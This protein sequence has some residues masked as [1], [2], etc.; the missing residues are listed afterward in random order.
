[1]RRRAA[2]RRDRAIEKGVPRDRGSAKK[3]EGGDR[4]DRSGELMT[5]RA[6]R[7]RTASV[8]RL[9]DAIAAEGP[10]VAKILSGSRN[11]NPLEDPAALRAAFEALRAQHEELMVADEELREQLDETGRLGVA[12]EAERE[13][14]ADLFAL[15]PDAIVVTDTFGMIHEAND[16]AAQLFRI[17]RRF[18]RAKPLA[19]LVP[20]TAGDVI[21][22]LLRD[23]RGCAD[24]IALRVRQR[25]GGEV[26]VEARLRAT[27]RGKSIVWILREVEASAAPVSD[28][29]R[30]LRDRTELLERERRLR[31]ELERTNRAKD[32]FIAVLAHDL[33]APLN[34]ILGWTQLLQQEQLDRDGRARALATIARN[35]TA[36]NQLVEE[37][38]DIARIDEHQLQLTLSALDFGPLVERGVARLLSD[39]NESG[40]DLTGSCEPGLTV[41][42][43]RSRLDQILANLLANALEHTPSGGKVLVEATREGHRVR[44]RVSDTGKGI[45]SNLLPNVFQLYTQDRTDSVSRTG[46][47]LGLHIV[48]QLVELHDGTVEAASDGEGQG[49]RV[50][51]YLPLH[52]ER[53]APSERALPVERRSLSRL[54]VLVVDDERDERELIGAILARAGATVLCA[55][56]H[57]SALTLF[58]ARR[59]DVVVSDI[60]MPDGDGCRLLTALRKRDPQLA[61]LAISGYA[62]AEDVSHAIESGFDAHLG[63]PLDAA[64]LVEL[65]DEAAALHGR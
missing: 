65:V 14:Y 1:V 28:R 53:A 35:A 42:G 23:A 33:R 48:K 63:K 61:A 62:M 30:T 58:E 56:G 40:I 46:L 38:L 41:I 2:Y 32:R 13:R 8:G 16:A 49:T 26:P 11:A 27:G 29:E 19:A 9:R 45:G 50:T 31:M 64:E 12:L 55:H 6:R 22:D 44:L 36:Q 4:H 51:V 7:E 43:D 34:A 24:A 54:S 39:A 21:H 17:D 57:A 47:G 15:A 59:P 20:S 52:A 18:L 25:G 3:V 60:A 5:L 10:L 37:L